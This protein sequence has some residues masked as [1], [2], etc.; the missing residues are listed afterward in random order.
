MQD[1][2]VI[3]LPRVVVQLRLGSFREKSLPKNQK[4]RVRNRV[5]Y[6]NPATTEPCNNIG[7]VQ[8]VQYPR[9]RAW[10]GSKPQ[11]FMMQL[12]RLSEQFVLP[13]DMAPI[14]AQ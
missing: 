1:D 7:A 2:V 6:T 3:D 9:G 12:L 8:C 13:T 11:S 14:D 10:E 4:T 5:L